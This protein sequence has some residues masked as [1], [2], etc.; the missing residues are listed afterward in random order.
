MVSLISVLVAAS[1]L[2][3]PLA[4]ASGGKDEYATDYSPK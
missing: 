4:I 2:V 3:N 1:L